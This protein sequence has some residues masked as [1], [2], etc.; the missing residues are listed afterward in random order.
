MRGEVI[1]RKKSSLNPSRRQSQ[2]MDTYLKG[3]AK[4]LDKTKAL[5]KGLIILRLTGSDGGEYCLDCSTK[6]VRVTKRVPRN[7][8][9]IEIM[10]EAKRIRAIF[11]GK[12]DARA[13]FLAGGFRIRGDLRYLSDLAIKLD[14]IKEPL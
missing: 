11:D 13:Q 7:T 5:K 4:R 14:I 6:S 8:S 10:G 3:F 2:G 12:K 9:L 1:V